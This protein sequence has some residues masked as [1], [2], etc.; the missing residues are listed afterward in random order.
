MG[1]VK[2]RAPRGEQRGPGLA[3]PIGARE[4]QAQAGRERKARP[5]WVRAASPIRVQP[6]GKR[7][8][9]VVALPRP[10]ETK[11]ADR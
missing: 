1:P 4:R 10:A 5:I 2:R 8:A 11:E 3:V 7:E 6:A 9:R